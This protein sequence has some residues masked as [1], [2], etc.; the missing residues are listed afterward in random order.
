MLHKEH[1][2]SNAIVKVQVCEHKSQGLDCTEMDY[3]VPQIQL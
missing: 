2:G 3:K 1:L